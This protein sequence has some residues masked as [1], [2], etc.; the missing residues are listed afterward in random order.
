M[1]VARA[2]SIGVRNRDDGVI[3]GGIVSICPKRVINAEKTESLHKESDLFRW[4]VGR[5]LEDLSGEV[6]GEGN[7]LASYEAVFSSVSCDAEGWSLKQSR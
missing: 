3:S 4:L 2:T 5:A 7:K 1:R 6:S